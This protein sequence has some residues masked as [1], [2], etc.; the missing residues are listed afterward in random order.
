MRQRLVREMME[1]LREDHECGHERWRY[2]DGGG[3]CQT[4]GHH[5]PLYLFV[6]GA[7]V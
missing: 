3:I 4:C 6:S 7:V 5:L 1:R 2:R